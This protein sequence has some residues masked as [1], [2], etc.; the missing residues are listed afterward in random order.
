[1]SQFETELLDLLG[2][3]PSLQDALD[4]A[5]VHFQNPLCLYDA[6]FRMHCYSSTPATNN[7]DILSAAK[8]AQYISDQILEDMKDQHTLEALKKGKTDISE[9]FNGYHAMRHP[10][11][12]DNTFLGFIGLYDYNHPYQDTDQEDLRSLEKALFVIF[13]YENPMVS[14][15]LDTYISYLRQ[16]VQAKDREA[17]KTVMRHNYGCSFRQDKYLVVFQKEENCIYPLKRIAA[18]LEMN[19][20]RHYIVTE[21]ENI[22]MLNEMDHNK[23][24]NSSG[25]SFIRQFCEENHL[26]AAISYMYDEDD[27]TPCAYRQCLQLLYHSPSEDKVIEFSQH[28]TDLLL[29]QISEAYTPEFYIRPEILRIAQYDKNY[30]TEYLRTISIYLKNLG[31]M[32][33]TADILHIHY[34]TIKYRINQIEQICGIDIHNDHELMIQ[35]YLS[36]LL[37][38]K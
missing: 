2:K 9:L 4:L 10:L 13:R 14:S 36:I 15:D 33:K 11:M 25:L 18:M 20:M 6:S 38:E 32:R 21:N 29:L 5:A 34:N 1:M 19:P 22:I 37:F 23:R 30:A 7:E 16:L 3:A 31:N 26:R 8:E 24:L 17:A 27:F 28:M 35:L 12:M